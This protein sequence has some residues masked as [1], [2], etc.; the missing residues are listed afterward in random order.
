MQTNEL[1]DS[2]GGAEVSEI[3]ARDIAAIGFI[4]LANKLAKLTNTSQLEIQHSTLIEAF[5]L[6]KVSSP[7][8]LDCFLLMNFPVIREVIPHE[9]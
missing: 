2:E 4:I 7:E 6:F 8:T 1:N 9:G 5:R 3:N